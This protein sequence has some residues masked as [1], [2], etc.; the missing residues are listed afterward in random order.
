ML[1]REILVIIKADR[2]RTGNIT[3]KA[4]SDNLSSAHITIVIK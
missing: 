1:I 2:G 4:S 3:V